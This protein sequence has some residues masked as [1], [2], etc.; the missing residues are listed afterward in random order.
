M[1]PSNALLSFALIFTAFS[2]F[3]RSLVTLDASEEIVFQDFFTQPAGSVTNCEQWIDVKGNGWQSGTAPTQLAL[4]GGGHLYNS[5]TNA[6]AAAGVPLIPI[7][8]HGSFTASALMNLP[9][10]SPEWIGLGFANSNLFLSATA[11]G[12]GPWLQV[13]G[14]GTMILYGGA[15]LNNATPVAGAFTNTGNVIQVFLTY[16]AFSATAS[17]GTV[18]GGLTNLVF[19]RWPLTNSTG[20]VSSRFLVVQISTNL[21]TPTAR[22]ATALSVDWFPRPLPMLT[23][24]VSIA[25]S[26]IIQVG[27]PG[28]NDV[29]LIQTAFNKAA[30]SPNAMEILFNAGATYVISNNFQTPDVPLSLAYATNT[31]VNGNG[32]KILIS[33]PRIG[34]LG[35][36]FCSNVIVQGFS[37]DY[38]PLP[39]TQGCGDLQLRNPA[40][41]R[42][43]KWPS[44]SRWIRAIPRP[45]TQITWTRMRSSMRA[46]GGR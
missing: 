35:V 12:S 7:G 3:A 25:S 26:N 15:G 38:N 40:V 39:Y 13:Q 18:H 19:N 44:N 10:N 27:S 9:T 30:N 42:P 5:A 8:P 16:D 33:N 34:F 6:G 41:P 29:A 31:L 21:T 4:D 28:T 36:N 32:C 43:K 14:N 20:P 11:G 24:P 37:V 22:W 45:R 23:L 2:P 17:A 1:R 46:A